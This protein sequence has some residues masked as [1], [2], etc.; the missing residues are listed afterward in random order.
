VRRGVEELYDAYRRVSLVKKDLEGSRFLRIKHI[1]G[2]IE[3]GRLD[4]DLRWTDA[5]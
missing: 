3:S 4:A 5:A 2:L 1:L